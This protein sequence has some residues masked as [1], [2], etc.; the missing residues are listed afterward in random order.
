MPTANLEELLRVHV[1]YELNMLFGT[2]ERLTK[3]IEDEVLSNALIESFCLHARALL[4]FF[5]NKHLPAS[6]F[7]TAAYK[8]FSDGELGISRALV[9]KLNTQI[10]HLTKKRVS[11]AKQKIGP[12]EWLQLSKGLTKAL[13]HFEA[14]LRSPYRETW[15]AYPSEVTLVLDGTGPRATNHNWATSSTT[16]EGPAS[17]ATVFTPANSVTV[18]EHAIRSPKAD[19]PGSD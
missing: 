13:R 6:E 18:P 7:T 1:R 3:P 12:D 5:K 14:H 2:V 17:T 11:D 4:D 8:P 15:R 9:E 16:F 19:K 10:A